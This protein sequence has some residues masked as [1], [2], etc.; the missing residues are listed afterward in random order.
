MESTQKASLIC[1]VCGSKKITSLNVL[2]NYLQCLN[3]KVA[4]KKKFPKASYQTDY[5]EPGSSL[6]SFLFSPI[7]S[8][9][10]ALRNRYVKGVKDLWIDVG[11]GDGKFLESVNAKRKVGVEVS[12]AARKIMKTRGFE[13]LTEKEFLETSNLYS[14]V[15]SFWQ[16]LEHLEQPQKYLKSSWANLK[17]GGEIIVAV[18]NIDSFEFK[19]FGNAWFHLTPKF[20]LWHF[21]PESIGMLLERQGFKIK[22]IDFWSVEHHLTGLLQSFINKTSGSE[23]TLHRLVKSERGASF[24]EFSAKEIFWNV[25]WITLGLPIVGI[26]WIFSSVLKEPGTFVVVASKS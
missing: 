9:F 26:F 25:F 13:V 16:V 7:L 14:D 22:K 6:A 24:S 4:W 11:A 19:F 5:Y 2:G 23:N 12:Q 17:K 20:H 18:P 21:S 3:C 15:I 8:F 1:P 10:Y